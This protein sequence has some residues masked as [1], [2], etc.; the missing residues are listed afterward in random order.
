MCT[1]GPPSI[2]D[3]MGL[4]LRVWIIEAS[5]IFLVGVAMHTCAVE[6]YEGAF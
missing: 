5:G 2:P 4:S 3:T 1:V 6:C